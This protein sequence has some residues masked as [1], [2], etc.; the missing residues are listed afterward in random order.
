MVA[1]IRGMRTNGF[2]SLVR[3]P[4]LEMNSSLHEIERNLIALQVALRV[5]RSSLPGGRRITPGQKL[6]REVALILLDEGIE[7]DATPNGCLC[8]IVG[9]LLFAAGEKPSNVT[10]IVRPILAE[11]KK[12]R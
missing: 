4:L 12:P 3:E 6:T 10:S 5:G 2:G 1:S 8:G 9:V 7:I 11:V